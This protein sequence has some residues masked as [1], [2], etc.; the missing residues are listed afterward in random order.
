MRNTESVR[1]DQVQNAIIDL[2]DEIMRKYSLNTVWEEVKQELK[3]RLEKLM[4]C[5]TTR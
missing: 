4:G 5:G 3:Q 1:T 2:I